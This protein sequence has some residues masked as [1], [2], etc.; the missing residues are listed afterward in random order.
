MYDGADGDFGNPALCDSHGVSER[1][2]YK[3][4][5]ADGS[6]KK[7]ERN[8]ILPAIAS[9]EIQ[10]VIGTHALIEETVVFSSLGLAIID[11][12]HRFG[13]EQRSRLWTKNAVVP[14][15]LV[16]T[17]TPI[18]RT[19]AMTLYGDLDVSVID[20]LPPGRK[21]IQTVHRYDNKKAQLYD[22]LRK[23]I[24]QGRQVYVVYPLI[25][26]S[27][28]LDYKNLEEGF[29]T[30]KE[31]FPEYKVCMVH[32]KMKA[33]EQRGGNAE[34]YF[35]RGADID[36]DDRDRGWRERAERFRD[37]HRK[38]RTF[39]SFPVASASWTGGTWSGAVIL[40][41]CLFL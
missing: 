4:S 7:K 11:E 13:V 10:L 9:G 32:G 16:M 39:R 27:E 5:P 37:G 26:G 3:S 15:V 21:P 30:F 40:C 12:Q 35:R 8:K 19:L 29:E 36:G 14:H 31:V 28:K 24:G 33:A 6:T 20:E 34:V 1:Y 25:E 23:E 41:A 2:G 22:F 18:P 17:A 38:C